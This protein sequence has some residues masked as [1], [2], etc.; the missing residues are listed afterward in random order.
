MILHEKSDFLGDKASI[1]CA[2]PVFLSLTFGQS[3]ITYFNVLSFD[4]LGLFF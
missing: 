3:R 2:Q 4:S 1:Y